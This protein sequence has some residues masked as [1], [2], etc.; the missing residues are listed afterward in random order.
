MNL[1][2]KI[3]AVVFVCSAVY[4]HQIKGV[5][6]RGLSP[7]HEGVLVK[8]DPEA[9]ERS[10]IDLFNP[11]AE[12][13]TQWKWILLRVDSS[14]Y[15]MNYRSG[16]R[17]EEFSKALKTHYVAVRVGR[18]DVHFWATQSGIAGAFE[19][20]LIHASDMLPKEDLVLW[21][22]AMGIDCDKDVTWI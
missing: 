4:L 22:G 16:D 21:C 6:M 11:W 12:W 1:A 5:W 8:G 14:R 20:S 9:V 10:F 7:L 2:Y 17:H 13:R 15:H 3:V 19:K 18:G